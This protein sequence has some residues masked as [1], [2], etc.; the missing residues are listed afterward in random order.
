M[1]ANLKLIAMIVVDLK[2][3]T[4]CKKKT[5]ML[6]LDVAPLVVTLRVQSIL[7]LF[8]ELYQTHFRGIEGASIARSICAYM[9]G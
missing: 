8:C 9:L 5:F 7:A 3:E 1:I 4:D 6:I 2:E